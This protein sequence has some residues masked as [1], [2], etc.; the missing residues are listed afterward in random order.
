[1]SAGAAC[2]RTTSMRIAYLD[3]FSGI[4]GDMFLGALVDAGVPFKLFQ[5]TVAALDIGATMEAS[6]VDRNGISATKIDV[7]VDGQKEMPHEDF[8]AHIHDGV[9]GHTYTRLSSHPYDHGHDL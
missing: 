5:D 4:S 6:R 1:M 3:G 7:I 2:Q 9:G 8:L